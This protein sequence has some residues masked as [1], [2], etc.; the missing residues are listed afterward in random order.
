MGFLRGI[1][2]IGDRALQK[3]AHKDKEND[4]SDLAERSHDYQHPLTVLPWDPLVGQ[5]RSWRSQWCHPRS[6]PATTLL[7]AFR[8]RT[9]ALLGPHGALLRWCVAGPSASHQGG[10]VGGI[11]ENQQVSHTSLQTETTSE[12]PPTQCTK[13]HSSIFKAM[14]IQ[15]LNW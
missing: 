1:F 14:C 10:A 15:A 9:Q 8:W 2:L 3:D 13:S 4:Q 12:V 11:G 5:T 6:F 7:W